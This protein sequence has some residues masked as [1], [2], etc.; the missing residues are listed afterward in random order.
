[1]KR[2]MPALFAMV[3]VFAM[4]SQND[5]GYTRSYTCQRYTDNSVVDGEV[6]DNPPQEATTRITK[7]IN[8]YVVKKGDAFPD[9]AVLA[10]DPHGRYNNVGYNKTMAMNHKESGGRSYFVFYFYKQDMEN[11][12]MNPRDN[13]SR[14]VVVAG[15][16]I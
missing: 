16:G 4:A 6:T 10:A 5:F 15:C 12:N 8:G 11:P 9:G 3:P 13:V 1:M 14:L 7:T 2:F